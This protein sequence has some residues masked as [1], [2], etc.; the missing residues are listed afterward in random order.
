MEGSGPWPHHVSHLV[1]RR[2]TRCSSASSHSESGSPTTWSTKAG[3]GAPHLKLEVEAV[4]HHGLFVFF[5]VRCQGE[6]GLAGAEASCD[7]ADTHTSCGSPGS[8]L[9][10]TC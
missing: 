9:T 1:L 4:G 10:R 5:E 8:G 2:T 3:S 6:C 7:T